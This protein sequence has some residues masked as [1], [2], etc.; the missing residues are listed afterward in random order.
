MQGGC[1]TKS[2]ATLVGGRHE[3]ALHMDRRVVKQMLNVHF[4]SLEN[5]EKSL[6]KV[7]KRSGI[8]LPQKSGSR[9][10]GKPSQKLVF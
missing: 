4:F 5:R 1:V 2:H 7:L 9:V 8:L 3:I 6:E 10:R